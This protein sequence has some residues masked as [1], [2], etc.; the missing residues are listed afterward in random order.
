MLYILK[1]PAQA[2][3]ANVVCFNTEKKQICY[4]YSNKQILSLTNM[5]KSSE[6]NSYGMNSERVVSLCHT[7]C[8]YIH[9]ITSTKS[10]L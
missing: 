3:G 7:D 8:V 6:K 4:K 5:P 1:K 9:Y 2:A 10:V